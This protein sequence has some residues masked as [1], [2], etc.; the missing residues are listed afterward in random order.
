MSKQ[1]YYNII[2]PLSVG[3]IMD[4]ILIVSRILNKCNAF[5]VEVAEVIK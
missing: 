5:I 3:K 1:E 4:L 2:A